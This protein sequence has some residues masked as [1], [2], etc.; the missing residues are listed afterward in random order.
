MRSNR[1]CKGCI[2]AANLFQCEA[3]ADRIETRAAVLF[4]MVDSH[5]TLVGQHLYNVVGKFL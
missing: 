4:I 5:Q 2:P 3:E 1:Q